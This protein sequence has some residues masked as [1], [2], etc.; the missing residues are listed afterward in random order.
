MVLVPAGEFT[1]GSAS[2][3]AD[4]SPEHQVFLDAFFIDKFEV[5][6]SQYQDF[7]AATDR[8]QPA[9]SDD[10]DLN[11]DDQPVVGVTWP[12][13]RDYCE[14]A[15]L[16]LPTE[17]EWEKA[18]R[19]S[20]ALEYPWGSGLDASK[21]NLGAE[22]CCEGSAAD[23]FFFSAPVGTYAE[24]VSVFGVHDMA[25]NV[26]EWVEDFYQADYYSVSP[27]SNPPGPESAPT[28]VFRGGS[29]FDPSDRLRAANR[30]SLGGAGFDKDGGFR[31]AR[32]G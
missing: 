19:G 30:G 7:V 5:T 11:G 2:G 16:R 4:E 27:A 1:M 8:A 29:W 20:E 25:G 28:R 31:C 22:T 15:L 14:W 26:W 6:N 21:A 3:E 24:G 9:F 12:D 17:A 10:T 13:A 32:D 18:A 23:G